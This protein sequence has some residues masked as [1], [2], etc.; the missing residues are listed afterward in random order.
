MTS[1]FFRRAGL[2][3]L[4]LRMSTLWADA[5]RSRILRSTLLGKGGLLGILAVVNSLRRIG[6][7]SLAG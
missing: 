2:F 6:S 5:R 4:R 3:L 7:G 1:F